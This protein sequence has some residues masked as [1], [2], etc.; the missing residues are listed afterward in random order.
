M[1]HRIATVTRSTK[2][3]AIEIRVDLDGTGAF[4]IDTGIGFFDH[5]V[6]HIAKHG[7]FDITLKASGDL[8]IDPHH[9]IED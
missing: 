9:T 4:D 8:H 5:M 6:T 3:T 7:V 2:E 1:N